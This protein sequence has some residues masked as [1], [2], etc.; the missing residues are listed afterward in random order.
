MKTWM[1]QHL[2]AARDAFFYVLSTPGNFLFNVFVVAIALSLP[3]AT[4]T[5]IDN[6]RPIASQLA[7][8]TEV[9][10]FL[11]KDLSKEQT[12]QLASHIMA[13]IKA[14]QL[15]A[16][17]DFIPKEA[18]LA[19]LENH[20]GLGDILSTLGE[21]P[22]PDAYIL[23]FG[24]PVLNPTEQSIHPRAIESVV[25]QL[26]SH[27]DIEHIQIDSNW[28]KR[29]AALIGLVQM[30]LTGLAAT[31]AV[32]IL[33][34]IFNATKLQALSHKIEIHVLELLG[35]TQPYVRRP[36][37]YAGAYLGLLAGC[38]ALGLVASV[39]PPLNQAILSFA[40]LYGSEF[41]LHP[42]NATRSISF[43]LASILLGL[44]G[45]YL[46]IRRLTHKMH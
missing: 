3:I 31:L 22:L 17:L 20:S 7:L 46:S 11:K 15:D 32:V 27:P 9:S 42:L 2:N 23:H 40:H 39:L 38:M 37:Y 8:N 35:A 41:Q 4:F 44:L 30:V 28:V 36:Y 34:V 43:I 14:H 1:L 12:T 24:Q 26:Q 18:A 6:I 21:N 45:T 19:R 25:Q 5:L 29:L 33:T 10:V 16:T 13:A